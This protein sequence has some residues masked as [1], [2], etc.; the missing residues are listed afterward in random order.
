M[1]DLVINSKVP[2][3][4]KWNKEMALNDARSIMEKYKGLE[5]TEEQLPEAKKELASLRKVSKE[6]NKQ[7]LDIDKELTQEVKQ[8]RDDV[9]EVIA[10]VNESVNEIDNQ[11][12]AFEQNQKDLKKAEILALP[13]YQVIKDYGVFNDSWLLKKY[14]IDTIMTECIDIKTNIDSSINTIK[15]LAT[16]H[17]MESDKYVEKLKSQPLELILERI[18]EDSQLL[19]VTKVDEKPIVISKDDKVVSV[20]RKL[21][22]TIQSLKVLKE[23][24]DKIGVKWEA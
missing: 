21:T 17:N 23:Y 24:A 18:V 15:L 8:F 14:D 12:K 1:N 2:A 5:F 20:T 19:K 4:V 6:I 9:K 11:V 16:S 22:G 13:E 10:I 7:A 3:S